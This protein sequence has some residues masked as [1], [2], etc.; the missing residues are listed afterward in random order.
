MELVGQQSAWS[1]RRLSYERMHKAELEE[2]EATPAAAP[3]VRRGPPLSV[4]RGT[5]PSGTQDRRERFQDLQAG[6]DALPQGFREMAPAW[7][8]R[9]LLGCHDAS[10]AGRPSEEGVFSPFHGGSRERPHVQPVG[11]L[12]PASTPPPPGPSSGG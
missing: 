1:K 8:E 7:S 5:K 11:T 12:A 6:R 9:M 4:S 3:L 2:S 10:H